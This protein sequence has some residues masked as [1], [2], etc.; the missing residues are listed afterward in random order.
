VNG[1]EELLGYRVST[2]ATSAIVD[3][4]TAWIERG[5]RAKWLACLNPHSYVVALDAPAFAEALKQAD[6]LIPDGIGVVIASRMLGG[7]IHERVTGS[8]LFSG[9]NAR[10]NERGR[11]RVFFL[12]SSEA[13]LAAIR[14][15]MRRDYPRVEVVGTY[16]PPFK[17]EF[18]DDDVE[19][20]IDAISA[21]RADVLWV[22]MT[23][24]KQELWI[25]RVRPRLDVRFSAAIGAVF[26]FYTGRIKRSRPVYQ[27]LGVEW[28]PRLLQEPRRLWRRMF[29]SAPIFLWHVAKTRLG[30]LR[31]L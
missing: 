17:P 7:R 9:I 4:I 29:I 24:P 23:A 15:K 5:D 1:A 3:E 22:G 16:S 13:T 25:H 19:A 30:M 31:Q 6:W 27:R 2:G 14:D 18:S 11:G 21:A 28:L 20:M 8:D 12:G 10:L 26:D